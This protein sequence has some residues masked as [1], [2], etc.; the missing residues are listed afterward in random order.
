MGLADVFACGHG[1][2]TV[3]HRSG[4]DVAESIRVSTTCGSAFFTLPCYASDACRSGSPQKKT[5][6]SL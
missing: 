2:A 5:W 1:V 3:P 6:C 4:I